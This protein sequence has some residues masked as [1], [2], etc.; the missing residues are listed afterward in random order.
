MKIKFPLLLLFI[1]FFASFYEMSAQNF[2]KNIN[3]SNKAIKES[4]VY[5]KQNVP[6]KFQLISIKENDFKAFLKTKSKNETKTLKL[7]NTKGGFSNFVIREVSNFETKLAEKF[8]NIKSYAAQG[9]DD[10]TAVAKISFG[11][12]GFHA[13]IFSG[14]EET[15]YIDP[16]T[17]DNKTLIAYRRNDLEI[18]KD[19]FTCHVED[20]SRKSIA[21]GKARVN[22][23]D[24]K[25]RTFRLAL[26]CSGEY[27]QFHLTN[28]NIPASATDEVKKAAVLSA[29]NTTMTRVNGVFERDLSVRMIIVG[30]NDK[31]IFL[32]PATDNITDGSP[33]L[34][35]NEV[36]SICDNQIENDNYDIGHLF[37]IGGDGL[38]GGGVVCF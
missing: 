24:G 11:T 8:S 10:P 37:S 2:L 6:S 32:N 23:D 27:A 34:M 20:S 16:Y 18:N 35:I 31:V 5:K 33:S 15:L 19:G 14:K 26:V 9:I 25:L 4:R 30:D 22:T 1:A 36:Q 38:A 28:Q 21:Q 17:K 3:K 7:P 12:D 13:V 29:M